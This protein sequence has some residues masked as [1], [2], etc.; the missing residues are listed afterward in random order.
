MQLPYL[1]LKRAGLL[2]IILFFSYSFSSLAQNSFLEGYLVD[3]DG[4]KQE[5]FIKYSAWKLTPQKF[6]Y[7]RPGSEEVLTA[8]FANV[9]EVAINGRARFVAA[10]VRVDQSSDRNVRLEVSREPVW[11]RQ[12]L[13]LEELNSGGVSLYF[14]RNTSFERFF[15]QKPDSGEITQL[16]YK[17]FKGQGYIQYNRDYRSQLRNEFTCTGMEADLRELEY[18]YEDITGYFN[19][20]NQ[21]MGYE[22]KSEAVARPKS[23][24]YLGLKG[25]LV[26]YGGV[27]TR[28]ELDIA[29][30]QIRSYSSDYESAIGARF[31][32][33]GELV[34]PQQNRQ[35]SV[36]LE[37]QFE[38][39]S[40]SGVWTDQV[41]PLTGGGLARGTQPWNIKVNHFVIGAG[42]RRYFFLNDSNRLFLNAGLNS[43]FVIDFGSRKEQG[44]V[45]QTANTG[46]FI[47][48]LFERHSFFAGFGL[49]LNKLR[50][51]VRYDFPREVFRGDGN[52]SS[53]YRALSLMAAFQLT[54]DKKEE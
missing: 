3:K 18:D 7:K 17:K 14:Y 41:F 19:A 33:Y 27:H 6:T 46:E 13:F 52:L 37:G 10:A 49:A 25:G 48:D 35:W 4:N 1:S 24:F 11:K 16:V 32:V 36:L 22:A 29:L 21:C 47:S 44:Q 12:E 34:L 42:F 28:D 26:S 31:G 8:E 53:K 45:A 38:S 20:Y 23:K 43:N 50:L 30:N 54:K 51:E 40:S 9:S 39:F 2:T 5:V 15:Y